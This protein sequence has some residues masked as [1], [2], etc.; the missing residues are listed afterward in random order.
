[1]TRGEENEHSKNID[2]LDGGSVG[3]DGVARICAAARF[4]L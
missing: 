1:M 4:S 3:D 2:G